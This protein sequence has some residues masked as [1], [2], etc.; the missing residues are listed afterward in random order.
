M[1][2]RSACQICDKCWKVRCSCFGSL[3]T[4]KTK[5]KWKYGPKPCHGS[6]CG[7]SNLQVIPLVIWKLAVRNPDRKKKQEAE[8]YF[9]IFLIAWC[10]SNYMANYPSPT[11][12]TVDLYGHAID[13]RWW[14]SMMW[15][16]APSLGPLDAVVNGSMD[17]RLGGLRFGSSI[18]VGNQL[19]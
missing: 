11:C 13:L 16:A 5:S 15:S 9:L 6:A 10:F 4:A 12:C 8:G 19:V 17:L 3:W 2:R 1:S 7:I 18:I 14:M